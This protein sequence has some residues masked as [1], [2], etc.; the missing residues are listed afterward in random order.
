MSDPI[1]VANTDFTNL[2]PFQKSM[3]TETETNSSSNSSQSSQDDDTKFFLRFYANFIQKPWS[4]HML[5]KFASLEEAGK[6]VFVP[7]M[8]FDFL[9]YE[10]LYTKLPALRV[11]DEHA[12]QIQICWTQNLS[13][14]IVKKC[15]MYYDDGTSQ[16]FDTVSLDNYRQ[17]FL[18]KDMTKSYDRGIG[19][20]PELIKWSHELP[21]LTLKAHQPWYF[22]EEPYYAVPILLFNDR[23]DTKKTN[24]PIR[25]VYEFNLDVSKLLRMR[26]RVPDNLASKTIGVY[27]D[28]TGLWKDIPLRFE[29]LLGLPL[30]GKLQTP[31]LLG[32]HV[33]VTPEEREWFKNKVAKDGL[34][35][36]ITDM[37]ARDSGDT[38]KFGSQARIDIAYSSAVRAVLFVAENMESTRNRSNSN[39]TTDIN[40]YQ[41]KKGL[42]FSP[43]E[44]YELVY[45][46]GVRVPRTPFDFANEVEP[47]Y[48][49]PNSRQRIEP[50]YGA[51]SFGYGTGTVVSDTTVSFDKSKAEIVF[52]LGITNPYLQQSSGG[53]SQNASK[54]KQT[55]DDGEE[56]ED[57]V[58]RDL[59]ESDII[60]VPETK[61]DSSS[62]F[63]IHVRT[64]I[65]KK[66]TFGLGECKI[67]S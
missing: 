11:K 10:L 50:G 51:L 26:R 4:D 19:N 13:H 45:F 9:L 41:G 57:I 62:R 58:S 24:T 55:L 6:M 23:T 38:Y 59:F 32:R 22:S 37:L 36:H 49:F 42:T 27:R 33:L 52:N 56:E 25:F 67:E 63:T 66:L 30:N 47:A 48:H 17:F 28:K 12:S 60:S 65:V 53:V 54:K 64:V 39:Y 35:I 1:T 3:Y 21:A 20:I 7:N 16:T 31:E 5:I 44:T 8:K 14:S 2:T 15:E 46:N 34:P 40:Y 61:V 18:K 29:Y 43:I